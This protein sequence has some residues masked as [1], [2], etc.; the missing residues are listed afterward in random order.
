MQVPLAMFQLVRCQGCFGFALKAFS[1]PSPT[2]SCQFL[3]CC[4]VAQ[5]SKEK[6]THGSSFVFCEVYYQIYALLA[7]IR[8]SSKAFHSCSLC[9]RG[10]HRPSTFGHQP[11][12]RRCTATDPPRAVPTQLR[13]LAESTHSCHQSVSRVDCLDVI[14]CYHVQLFAQKKRL[15][16]TR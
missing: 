5:A 14:F 11:A 3:L 9:Y 16:A 15:V 13:Q 6:V 1:S 8:S 10:V 12:A 2:N 7:S 4:K